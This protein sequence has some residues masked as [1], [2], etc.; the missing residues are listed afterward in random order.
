MK[1][2]D[3]I[4]DK[5]PA[6]AP[7]PLYIVAE[8]GAQDAKADGTLSITQPLPN[9]SSW[10][11]HALTGPLSD[12]SNHA[13]N[14]QSTNQDTIQHTE[15][16]ISPTAV[17]S[18]LQSTSPLP[19]NHTRRYSQPHEPRPSTGSQ[20]QSSLVPRYQKQTL[21]SQRSQF[22]LVNNLSRTN[23]LPST[24]GSCQQQRNNTRPVSTKP[25]VV[26]PQTALAKVPSLSTNVSSVNNI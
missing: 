4:C 13:L 3:I 11:S 8:L 2:G 25:R 24:H 9:L 5:S 1:R 22:T 18:F 23:L 6:V 19:H 16:S 20:R 26:E 15:S 17:S 12:T 10:D 7:S 21:A 14:L